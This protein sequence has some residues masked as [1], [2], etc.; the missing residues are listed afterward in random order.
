[1]DSLLVL[2]LAAYLIATIHIVLTFINKRRAMERVAFYSLVFG[3]ALH[4]A[5][6]IKE[7]IEEGRCPIYGFRDTFLFLAW[8]LVITYGV[9]TYRYQIRAIGI[10]TIPVVT[11]L[12]FTAIL[13]TPSNLNNQPLEMTQTAAWLSIHTALWIFTYTALFVVFIASIMYLWQEYE[14]KTKSFGAFFHRLPSLSTVNDVATTSTGIGFALLTTGIITGFLLSSHRD[15]RIWHN[16]PKEILA[17]LTW[18]VYLVLII[19]RSTKS[20]RANKAAWL[21]IAGFAFVLCTF[22]AARLLGSFHVFGTFR[23]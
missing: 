4:T 1:M 3:L 7:G 9:L 8:T 5:Y 15:G 21:G 18:F 10:F 22:F 23:F 20:W 16:D 13:M 6:F 2:T 19:Y 17:V 11:I 12:T 14:L